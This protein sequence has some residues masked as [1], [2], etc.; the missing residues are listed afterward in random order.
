[1]NKILS[2]KFLSLVLL[3]QIFNFWLSPALSQNLLLDP[4]IAANHEIFFEDFNGDG[5]SDL[6][7]RQISSGDVKVFFNAGATFSATPNVTALAISVADA[8]NWELHFA[9]MTDDGK[10]DLINMSPSGQ[11]FVHNNLGSSFSAQGINYGTVAVHGAGWKAIF[12]NV[13]GDGKADL[14]NINLSNGTV[15]CHVNTGTFS[16]SASITKTQLA[17]TTLPGWQ[18]LIAD[19]DGNGISDFVNLSLSENKFFF[20]TGT[21]TSFNS[22]AGF[23]G[24]GPR[25]KYEHQYFLSD[26]DGD[27]LADLIQHN[28]RNGE[29]LG[30]HGDVTADGVFAIGTLGIVRGVAAGPAIHT[31]NHPVERPL[32]LASRSINAMTVYDVDF[33]SDSTDRPV[34]GWWNLYPGY[35]NMTTAASGLYRSYTPVLGLYESNDPQVIT[36]QAYWM[37]AMGFDSVVV[38]WTNLRAQDDP[39]NHDLLYTQG[40][41]D[42][43]ATLLDT[44]AS[45]TEFVP[46]KVIIATRLN[47][48]EPT[49]ADLIADEVDA[50]IRSTEGLSPSQPLGDSRLMYRFDDG[51]SA[52]TKPL[53]LVFADVDNSWVTSGPQWADSR[54]NVRFS[55]GLFNNFSALA[56]DVNADWRRIANDGPYWNFWEPIPTTANPGGY[57]PG[58]AIFTRYRGLYKRIASNNSLIEQSAA[59]IA[60]AQNQNFPTATLDD[61][62]DGLLKMVTQD[63]Q[64]RSTLR[65]TARS[66]LLQPPRI[67]LINRFNYGYSVPTKSQEGLSFLSSTHMEPSTG[68]GFSVLND[69]AQ[70]VHEL[71]GLY[72]RAPSKPVINGVTCGGGD[73]TIDFSSS[74]FPTEYLVTT[75]IAGTTGTWTMFDVNMGVAEIPTSLVG[76]VV[77][78]RTRNPFG[79]SEP[80]L[81]ANYS[82]SVPAAGV[83]YKLTSKSSNKCADVTSSSTANGTIVQQWTCSGQTNQAWK[84]ER[85]GD[86]FFIKPQH[87]G[88]CMDVE[89]ASQTN[90]AAI[91]QWPCAAT[92]T[93]QQW[94]LN[95]IA[96]DEY[97]IKARHSGKCLEVPGASQNNGTGLVQWSCVG[98]QQTNQI[99]KLVP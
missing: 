60:I 72:K 52:R 48:G 36:Q 92:S 31:N 45:I 69:T 74:N 99:W 63:G 75:D 77:Y 87:S 49:A 44:Y 14:C 25:E 55:G 10:A 94:S 42:A 90:G 22:T 93:Q 91:K 40:V 19:V 38:D 78:L 2:R 3:L 61:D 8:T 51:T 70:V 86:Y 65:R 68:L 20:H 28:L 1:M 54:F 67:S 12:A 39:N 32:T 57:G 80:T 71:R 95:L 35:P 16:T 53:L 26:I 13:I 33:L 98:P 66:M 37:A 30:Y 79:V 11:V 50:L 82:G 64:S 21:G 81:V 47:P 76:E 4:V 83:F 88:K 34:G 23:V 97:Q 7:V 29:I 85:V 96:P 58:N 9:D 6:F 18:H 84:F 24:F 15:Y 59:W 89:N 41:K 62:W 17:V 27:G 56:T 43:T 5:K 73:C 46:P